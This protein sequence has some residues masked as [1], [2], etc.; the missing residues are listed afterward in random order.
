MKTLLSLDL[1]LSTGFAVIRND[2]GLS[3]YG[4]IQPDDDFE[5]ALK[6]LLLDAMPTHSMCER[7][8]IFKGPLGDQLQTRLIVVGR[9]LDHQVRYVEPAQWKNTR[10]KTAPIPKD[11]KSNKHEKDAIRMAMWY[12]DTKLKGL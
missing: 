10:Y 9:I 7:P 5:V 1:G 2:V 3:D 6:K 4:T 8:L 11:I 12:W